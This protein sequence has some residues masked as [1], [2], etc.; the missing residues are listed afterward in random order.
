M[1]GAP[2]FQFTIIIS[3]NIFM[4]LRI[5]NVCFIYFQLENMSIAG[6]SHHLIGADSWQVKMRMINRD[7]VLPR[8]VS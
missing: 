3:L 2:I 1:V 5:I 7:T 8:Q 6:A 4:G